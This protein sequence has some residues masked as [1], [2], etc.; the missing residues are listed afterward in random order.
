MAMA[1]EPREILGE[2]SAALKKT[3]VIMQEAAMTQKH[4]W[5][6]SEA[7]A[8]TGIACTDAGC[9]HFTSGIRYQA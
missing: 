4:E 3:L 8:Q 1:A 6:Y 9:C 7:R 5:Q 2:M